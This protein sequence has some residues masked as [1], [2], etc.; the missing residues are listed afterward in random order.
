[1]GAS[2]PIITSKNF[3]RAKKKHFK[4]FSNKHVSYTTG[5]SPEHPVI[6]WH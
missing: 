2:A 4:H 1:M 3:N 6:S 5:F